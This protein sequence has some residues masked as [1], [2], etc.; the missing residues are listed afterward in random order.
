MSAMP[1]HTMDRAGR[2][3]ELPLRVYGA[4]M[5]L[6]E[7]LAPMVLRYR[8]RNGKEDGAHRGERLGQA[9]R[10][11]PAGPLV[12]LHAAS[13]G[14]TN[15][16]M[17]LILRLAERHPDLNLLLTTGTVTSAALVKDRL[18]GVVIHQFVP[19]DGPTFLR[20][21]LDHWRPDLAVFVES[22]VWPNI[23]RALEREN[24]PSVM[25][26]GR[27]S[28]RSFRRWGHLMPIARRLFGAFDLVLAQS[29][30]HAKRFS[31]LGA[32]ESL[33]IG[34]LKFD[35]PPPPVIETEQAALRGAI[36]D[37]PV[38]LAASTHAGEDE[39]VAEVH[40]R[41][42]A[43]SPG[44]LTII[45]P[46]HPVRAPQ[47]AAS[48]AA[49][50]LSV[51]LRSE[52]GVPEPHVELFIADTIGEL[53]LLYSLAP[54]AFIGGSLIPHGGQNPVEAIKLASAVVTGPHWHNFEQ[55]YRNLIAAD[56][57]ME[58]A[59]ADDL[60]DALSLLLADAERRQAMMGRADEV[61]ETMTGALE[62]TL[63]HLER[64][65]PLDDGADRAA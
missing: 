46:R 25:V 24:I 14:E 50:G 41:L 7:T 60:A 29:A 43:Q 44:L 30:R 32:K 3:G 15:A 38:I 36:G 4:V 34:N 58:V 54:V 45:A 27:L 47:L 16:I 56:G 10:D 22:E 65:L 2:T 57:C 18:R 26:N 55:V 59:D 33:G 1:A 39:T 51:A 8:E 19:L 23:I 40:R 13:I 62:E 64:L 52:A 11:R 48:L 12:W 63:A 49:E 9:S 37:R 35:A 53:G 5:R 42:R 31:R 28:R 20:R 21:F 6:A 61:L 17:P